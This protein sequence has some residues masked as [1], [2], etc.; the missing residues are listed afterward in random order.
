MFL[1][2]DPRKPHEVLLGAIRWDVRNDTWRFDHELFQKQAEFRMS[3][4]KDTSSA[5]AHP[6]DIPVSREYGISY[7][8]PIAEGEAAWVVADGTLFGNQ[9]V[10]VI[11]VCGDGTMEELVRFTSKTAF[12]W[13]EANRPPPAQMTPE[14]N[15]VLPAAMVTR[16]GE[17][18]PQYLPTPFE[19]SV[20]RGAIRRKHNIL[21]PVVNGRLVVR[22]ISSP[23][24][25]PD[26]PYFTYRIEFIRRNDPEIRWT[27]QMRGQF[28]M[29]CGPQ[30]EWAMIWT[31]DPDE[32]RNSCPVIAGLD[33]DFSEASIEKIPGDHSV[34][35]IYGFF[36][37]PG[38]QWAIL[39]DSGI[40]VVQGSQIRRLIRI[41]LSI[42]QVLPGAMILH[43]GPGFVVVRDKETPVSDLESE[44][45]PASPTRI[46]QRGK[47][48]AIAFQMF[49]MAKIGGPLK[50]VRLIPSGAVI[51]KDFEDMAVTRNGIVL[52]SSIGFRQWEISAYRWDGTPEWSHHFETPVFSEKAGI[53]SMDEEILFWAMEGRHSEGRAVFL[54]IRP[55][56]GVMGVLQIDNWSP[57]WKFMKTVWMFRKEVALFG[58]RD[59]ARLAIMFPEDP[60]KIQLI[61]FA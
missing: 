34:P 50:G 14:G 55:P 22:R 35:D 44:T 45:L 3:D 12:S 24:D 6:A 41:P 15:L 26:D 33:G 32:D 11:R 40:V 8:R 20:W 48:V 5:P 38:G 30:S 10:R 54:R 18:L 9:V 1:V 4:E 59:G 57:R 31:N 27:K 53:C 16:E 13:W 17:L 51:R 21:I 28:K 49:S 52:V 36:Y 19:V 46:I 47:Y 23:E 61:L 25:D 56:D 60:G 29:V 39:H 37:L 2:Y 7:P 58:D 42:H 43:S